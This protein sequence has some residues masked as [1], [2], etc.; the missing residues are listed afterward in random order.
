MTQDSADS[1]DSAATAN[2]HTLPAAP[3]GFEQGA[4]LPFPVV[5]IGASAGGI[6]ALTAFLQSAP[7]DGGMAFVVIQHLPPQSQSLMPEI[8]G[9]CTPMPVMQIEDG[10]RVE[11]NAVYVIR[12][13][14]TVTLE[15]GQL[16][17]GEP[18]ESRG[19]RRPVDDFFRS[20]A[21]EQKERA[22]VV[23]LSGTGTNGTAGAQAVKAAG[24]VCV[25]QDPDTAEFP[26]MP[27]SLIRAGY[28]DQVL[29]PGAIA[30]FLL[31]YVRHPLVG[32]G[33]GTM[34]QTLQ[35][36]I[37]RDRQSINQIQALLRTRTGHDFRGYRRPTLLRRI[38]RRM[39]I[40]GVS[41]LS[42]YAQVLRDR[43]NEAPSLANDLLINVTGFFRDPEAWEALRESVVAPLVESRSVGDNLRAWVAACSSGEESYSLA[44]LIS[45]EI[46]RTQ[47]PLDVKIFATDAADKSLALARAGIY[48]AGIEGDVSQQRLERF[49]E[50][51]E[52][53]YRIRKEIR[54]MVVFAPQNL[55]R[56]PPF[57][58]VDICTC[59]NFLIYL[60]PET[61]KRILSLLTFAV[62]DGGY[63]FLGNTESL[64]SA[65]QNF[66]TVSK[67]WRLYRRVGP[68][69][70]R[71]AELAYQH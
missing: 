5:G 37:Q 25:A 28:A 16:R 60:E 68:A 9:R 15:R 8:L 42:G 55:L 18:V 41:S 29:P 39:G 22:I 71:F 19:H 14:Y 50:K 69:Q 61:Q 66:E 23:V 64:N 26:G 44:M 35:Q 6:E 62:R 43:S 34:E 52:H 11:P 48:P 32:A 33:S 12:P 3:I 49:F 70:H 65:E 7:A 2:S 47:K 53:T 63:L 4:N 56:D 17:L 30:E 1:P 45:E 54:D 20:L 46:Q 31:G 38:E 10:T 21:L 24:G 58:R 51:D 67:R 36:E 27:E 57:S 40:V 59:R 13:G